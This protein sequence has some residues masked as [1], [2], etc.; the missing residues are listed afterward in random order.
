MKRRA[1]FKTTAAGLCSLAALREWVGASA[2][3]PETTAR[4]FLLSTRGCGRATGYAETNKIV[5]VDNKTHVAWLDSVADGFRVRVRTLDRKTGEWSPVYTIGEAFDNH[6]GP[7]L[8][9]DSGGYLHAIYYP[10][11]HPFRHRRS[12]RPNDASEWGHESWLN[13]RCTYPTLLCGLDDSLYL[14][15][16][17][18]HGKEPWLVNLFVKSPGGQ[19]EG[20]HAILRAGARGYAHFQEA[21]A[22]G[23]DRRTLYLS[24]RIYDGS[25]GRGHT[26]GYLRSPDCGKTWE[27]S[28][29]TRVALPATAETVTNIADGR[30]EKTPRLRCGSMAVDP[31]G[32]PHVLYSST[33][34]LPSEVWIAS[35]DK[36]GRWRRRSLLP[37]IAKDWP[38]WGL[39]MPGGLTI[40]PDGRFFVVLTLIKPDAA[41]AETTWGHPSSEI[42]WLESA[43]ADKDFSVR[44]VS[45]PDPAVPHWLPNLERPTG[46][47]RIAG[48]PGLLY[49]SGIRGDNNRQ[50]LSNEVYWVG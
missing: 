45:K 30:D 27:R 40:G 3:P 35:L 50:I 21:L 32:A 31:S 8:T 9:V 46:H 42:V 16:R 41:D 23:P 37:E 19:W 34:R 25:P 15:A 14:T 47:N 28:D 4:P 33:A 5:T 17:Q 6:G 18:S 24:C 38:G 22:W 1:F 43:G 44:L 7:A 2:A 11:H 20:P 13:D 12:T 49:Q 48:R 10:H 39:T 36:S 29:G 26:V